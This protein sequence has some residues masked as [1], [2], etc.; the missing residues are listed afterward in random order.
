M[1]PLVVVFWLALGVFYFWLDNHKDRHCCGPSEITITT[2]AEEKVDAK[3]Y[4]IVFSFS[5]SDAQTSDLFAGYRD[6]VIATLSE[7]EVLEIVGQYTR[8]ETNSTTYENIGKARAEA[9]KLMLSDYLDTSRITT[10]GRLV[11]RGEDDQTVAKPRLAFGKKVRTPKIM[12]IDDRTLIYFPYNSTQRLKDDEI[13]TY[14]KAVAER[15]L[16][17]KE[18]IVLTGHTDSFGDASYNYTLGLAR[19]NMIAAVLRRNGIPGNQVEVRS[20][21]ETEP[22]APNNTEEGRSKNRRTELVIITN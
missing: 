11:D 15:V 3:I 8:E 6:S 10:S 12:E 2:P 14:L 17:S 13:E 5:S 9:V 1:K 22:I 16:K 18:E 19:A 4:P 20:K 21:G 7:N